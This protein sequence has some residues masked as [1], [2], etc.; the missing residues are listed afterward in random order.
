TFDG[1]A[2]WSSCSTDLA[3]ASITGLVVDPKDPDTVYAGI[4]SALTNG[5]AR[6]GLFKTTDGGLSWRSVTNSIPLDGASLAA[7]ALDPQ[8]SQT[9]YIGT[10]GGIFKSIDGGET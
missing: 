8:N 10:G 4:G 3:V 5:R 6:G 1:G 2:T 9:I 7:V